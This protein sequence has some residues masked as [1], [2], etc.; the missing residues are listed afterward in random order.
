[1]K[2]LK[3]YKIFEKQGVPDEI[4]S[5][6]DK[7]FGD[8]VGLFGKNLMDILVKYSGSINKAGDTVRRKLLKR[9]EEI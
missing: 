9:I 6:F 1:M 7:N 4:F 8:S 3:S 5:E 2:Y